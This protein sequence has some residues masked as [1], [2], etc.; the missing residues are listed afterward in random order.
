M[1]NRPCNLYVFL[2][3]M[4]DNTVLA[5]E[6]V[7]HLLFSAHL[8]R[9][10][11]IDCY[12]P[13]AKAP[14]EQTSLLLFNDG[15]DLRTIH[16]DQMLQLLYQQKDIEPVVCVAIHCAPDRKNEYGTASVLDYKGRGAKAGLY[17]LFVM[18]EL[19]PFIRKQY[20]LTSCK[21][22]VFAGFSLGGLSALDIVWTHPTEFSK[23]G[24]FSGSFWWRDRDT[25]DK[26]FDERTDRIMH[27]L[28]RTGQYRPWL[29]FFF[30]SGFLDETADRNNNG[31]IDAVDD[32][33][34][35]IKELVHKGY[36][37]S[38]DIVSIELK[39]GKHDL[40]TWATVLPQFMKWAFPSH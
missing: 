19:L 10:V 20:A 32:T 17:Q 23:V 25:E 4:I 5:I 37:A 21:Q 38:K 31:I 26:L 36:D 12:L 3:L 39:E 18:E 8:N 30:E 16:F 33:R 29:Q 13:T 6:I 15:Q 11:T 2:A 34:D 14:A 1:C 40:S 7:T 35:L 22:K 9:E 27:R 28:I 24:V